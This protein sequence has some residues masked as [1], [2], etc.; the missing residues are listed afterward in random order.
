MALTR[1]QYTESLR[2]ERE[3]A[4][5]SLTP[6]DRSEFDHKVRTN[7]L[8]RSSD[9][10][11]IMPRNSQQAQSSVISRNPHSSFLPSISQKDLPQ[12]LG[13]AHM[14]HAQISEPRD[15]GSKLQ[16]PSVHPTSNNMSKASSHGNFT[17][18]SATPT[19]TGKDFVPS[20]C[21][22]T[23]AS[24]IL[25]IPQ[26]VQPILES[27]RQNNGAPSVVT[28]M[29]MMG[30][31]GHSEHSIM[32]NNDVPNL[33]GSMNAI[34]SDQS[35]VLPQRHD[36][37]Q[38]NQQATPYVDQV[39]RPR[40]T[41]DFSSLIH[42]EGVVAQCAI[43]NQESNAS[44]PVKA[45]KRGRPPTMPSVMKAAVPAK[46]R[47]RGRPVGS[48]NKRKTICTTS[49]MSCPGNDSGSKSM[50]GNPP[51]NLQCMNSLGVLPVNNSNV[52]E[53]SP[54]QPKGEIGCSPSSN[55]SRTSGRVQTGDQKLFW[56]RFEDVK[57]TFVPGFPFLAPFLLNLCGQVPE[58]QQE[59][60]KKKI[61]FCRS[62][63]DT[64][65]TPPLH[66]T[67]EALHNVRKFLYLITNHFSPELRQIIPNLT[68]LNDD[69]RASLI[70]LL[71][72]CG[73]VCKVWL[74][75]E[76]SAEESLR[77][78]S[79]S[80]NASIRLR[81]D[82]T[83]YQQRENIQPRRVGLRITP[84]EQQQTTAN[85]QVPLTASRKFVQVSNDFPI[86]LGKQNIIPEE[87]GRS[88][89]S[90]ISLQTPA[91]QSEQDLP[92]AQLCS[93]KS[94]RKA[95]TSREVIKKARSPKKESS[96]SRKLTKISGVNG[97]CADL[98]FHQH[99]TKAQESVQLDVV[100][101]V[102]S[103]CKQAE[104]G[105]PNASSQQQ[106][107]LHPLRQKPCL[108]HQ[109]FQP[110]EIAPSKCSIPQKQKLQE[111]HTISEQV[112]TQL[113][114]CTTS[115]A[116][117]YLKQSMAGSK[118]RNSSQEKEQ[119]RRSDSFLLKVQPNQDLPI[120]I[121]P[122]ELIPSAQQEVTM[123]SS[124]D[125][126][127]QIV[128]VRDLSPSQTQEGNAASTDNIVSL[129]STTFRSSGIDLESPSFCGAA[130]F[131][132][133]ERDAATM[134]E[135]RVRQLEKVVD[136]AEISSELESQNVVN[137]AETERKLQ[138]KHTLQ[139]PFENAFSNTASTSEG[140]RE[141]DEIIVSSNP[142]ESVDNFMATYLP[143]SPSESNNEFRIS[144]SKN[145]LEGSSDA[146]LILESIPELNVTDRRSIRQ[147]VKDE[148][149][150]AMEYNPLIIADIKEEF[151]KPV[152]Y[153]LL[154][155]PAI[156]LPK[157]VLRI[158]SS[159]PRYGTTY[160]FERPP[161]GWVGAPLE[162]RSRFEKN[163]AE[164][165]PNNVGVTACLEAWAR[166][167]E[168]VLNRLLQPSD[169]RMI[170]THQNSILS[171]HSTPQNV[172]LR[173]GD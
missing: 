100:E 161:L 148:C 43:A 48:S 81:S 51:T 93:Q 125:K 67:F 173:S 23:A 76:K 88:A 164:A 54:I 91:E 11:F 172:F 25:V 133:S 122:P 37:P 78:A 15:L 9:H 162:V 22:N 129:V 145:A 47:K 169:R 86:Y 121:K 103:V 66:L 33:K 6:N 65:R 80:Q 44:F 2:R 4:A 101:E 13:Q 40:A 128:F 141:N 19:A 18:I 83:R 12:G 63:L 17:D 79:R 28:G 24:G 27:A 97:T 138:L 87:G 112:G 146:D 30:T 171:K 124:E 46:K 168:E 32:D 20:S 85:Q 157:M 126:L 131:S 35:K 90:P 38:N 5:S 59:I 52:P 105:E 26:Q 16:Q 116:V 89:L 118:I 71:D 10:P 160:A 139:I 158:F 153:C 57:K 29:P 159:C 45:R 96:K 64:N 150:A 114:K 166:A 1:L 147:I 127:K 170:R 34:N 50:T 3:A 61:T 143:S 107:S 132:K 8:N 109:I 68:V 137:S 167:A 152:V 102:G 163:L 155:T 77:S 115:S 82:T 106:M 31:L 49:A 62:L 165:S 104:I 136:D 142:T 123:D 92:I 151:R 74:R 70:L 117:N 135:E 156:R 99:Q 42:K 98:M 95:L 41:H 58:P 134:E 39:A 73:E 120:S 7:Q 56:I 111:D 69:A 94:N 36:H 130:K 140:Q 21:V 154:K 119:R 75:H 60:F 53:R 113:Q 149:K 108:P 14:H 110:R 72:Q 144:H 84:Q 55:A